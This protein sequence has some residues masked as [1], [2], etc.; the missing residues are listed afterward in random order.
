[1]SELTAAVRAETAPL[2][3]LRRTWV[4]PGPGIDMVQIR[5]TWSPPGEPPDWA[6]ADTRVLAPHAGPVRTAVLE[7]PLAGGR[8]PRV[9]PAP[10]LLRGQRDRPG[11]SPVFT[12]EIVTHEVTYE[13]PGRLHLGRRRLERRRRVAGAGRAELPR[14]RMDGLPFEP[15]GTAPEHSGIYEFVRAQPLPHVFRG[16]VWGSA[17]LDLRYA[18]HLVREG[19]PDPADDSER[20]DDNGG[21]GWTVHLRV[22]D[23][24][25][26]AAA[27]ARAAGEADGRARVRYR[28][29]L[30][31]G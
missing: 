18:Y 6:D 25:S 15:V 30:A 14:L 24:R 1:M 31:A 13:D 20:W 4:D 10:L 26:P 19:L 5:Y 11:L 7:V 3:G 8:G 2:F 23:P 28:G 9:L 22:R 29:P 21:S 12:E 16:R 27:M 17:A